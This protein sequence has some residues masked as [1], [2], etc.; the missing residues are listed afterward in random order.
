MG[1]TEMREGRTQTQVFAAVVAF[2]YDRDMH[3]RQSEI[4]GETP[5]TKGA[6]SN[7]T[8]TLVEFGLLEETTEGR[9][10]VA[11][12]ALRSEY[13]EHIETVLARERTIEPFEE[14][15][16]AH[17]DVRTQTKRNLDEILEADVVLAALVEAFV[18]CRGTRRIETFREVFLR[19]DEILRATA[20]HV[21]G[22][23]GNDDSMA[24]GDAPE[25]SA[26][27]SL[28]VSLNQAHE[29]VAGV[30]ERVPA[31][32]SHLPGDVPEDSMTA[33]LQ[34]QMEK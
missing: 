24:E 29:Q 30:G 10:R 7:H 16:E 12:G 14:R 17:N 8:S 27:L 23:I 2:N 13:R 22:S 32:E 15:V 34:Q 19:T 18:E 21:V 11:E 28:A 1:I 20:A 9:Y 4:V 25:V 26:L 5:A 33:Y 6:V 31:I 3:P